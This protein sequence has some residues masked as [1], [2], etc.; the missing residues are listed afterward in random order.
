MGYKTERY[1]IPVEGFSLR[2]CTDLS[3]IIREHSVV[4]DCE[5]GDLQQHVNR[6]ILTE[7]C[8]QTFH[9]TRCLHVGHQDYCQNIKRLHQNKPYVI[10]ENTKPLFHL[11]KFCSFV[12]DR[13]H[14]PLMLLTGVKL[15]L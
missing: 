4:D 9:Y 15:K 1:N 14:V 2:V 10:S 11:V 8:A 7:R 3:R 12:F 6:R 5:T 13:Q